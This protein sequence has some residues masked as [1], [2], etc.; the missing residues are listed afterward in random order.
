MLMPVFCSW[1]SNTSLQ[2]HTATSVCSW[3]KY[4][5]DFVFTHNC[6][7]KKEERPPPP[8]PTL[9]PNKKERELNLQ[10]RSVTF[11][12]STSD[13]LKMR[14]K[15]PLHYAHFL[16]P[17]IVIWQRYS[18]HFH[19]SRPHCFPSRFRGYHLQTGCSDQFHFCSPGLKMM[20]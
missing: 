4:A 19:H 7:R 18:F 15:S 13:A 20:G 10:Q 5:F 17:F 6:R 11:N 9:P 1:C 8:H 2:I 3:H 12:Y 16:L 14:G